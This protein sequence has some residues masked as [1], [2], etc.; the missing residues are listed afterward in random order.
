MEIS[1]YSKHRIMHGAAEW[2]VPQEFFEPIYNYLIHG[3]SP[4]SFYSSLLANNLFDAMSHC[5]PANPV[6]ALKN[7]TSWIRSMRGINIFWGSEEVVQKWL[8]LT[9][10]ERRE[11]LEQ[12]S[13]VYSEKDEIVMI[14]KDQKTVEPIFW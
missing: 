8:A 14:L 2:E 9:D 1:K 12:L 13:L 6:K 4:G 11:K 5:H 10:V 3:F 7:L